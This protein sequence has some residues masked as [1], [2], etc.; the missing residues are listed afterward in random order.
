LPS[1]S[2]RSGRIDPPEGLIA[3]ARSTQLGIR[4]FHDESLR[5][6]M[7]TAPWLHRHGIDAALAI[8][9]DRAGDAPLYLS[10]D[11]DGHPVEITALAT[12]H[13]A[14]DWLCALAA[15]A[16]RGRKR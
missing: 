2:G 13:I 10:F 7:L 12:A 11:I 5:L 9:R 16:G 3:P 1:R 6:E 14:H 4:T 15:Q 8:I